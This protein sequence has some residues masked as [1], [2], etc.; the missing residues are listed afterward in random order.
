MVDGELEQLLLS[1]RLLFSVPSEQDPT[2]GQ[3]AGWS[4][5]CALEAGFR[6]TAISKGREPLRKCESIGLLQAS[7]ADPVAGF[8]DLTGSSWPAGTPAG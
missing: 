5:G 7:A 4:G 3:G 1:T 2:N 6:S 8:P